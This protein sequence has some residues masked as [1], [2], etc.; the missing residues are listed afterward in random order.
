M[1][2]ENRLDDRRYFRWVALHIAILDDHYR[3]FGQGKVPNA[4]TDD[5]YYNIR[6]MQELKLR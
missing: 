6:R 1:S 4:M 2:L 5:R 3:A